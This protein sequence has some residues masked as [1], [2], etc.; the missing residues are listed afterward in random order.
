VAPV[1]KVSIYDLDVFY[2]LTNRFSLDLTIPY[3]TGSGGFTQGTKPNQRFVEWHANGIG[4]MTLQAEFWL[5]DTTKPSRLKGSVDLGIKAPTGSDSV[6]G[7]YLTPTGGEVQMPID[8]AAQP[9]NG[10]WELIFRAQ[11]QLELGGP[12]VAYAS[13]Y[14]GLSLTEHTSVHQTNPGGTVGPL[15][16]VPDTYS[17]RLGAG[18]LL[19][20]ADGLF[21]SVGGRINGVTVK[22]VIGGGD[23]YWRRPGYEVYVEPGLS[24]T[25]GANIASVSVP[26]RVYQNKLDSPLDQSLH[27]HVG[28]DFAPYLVV[29]SYARRF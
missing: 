1:R 20:F 25:L 7:L 27:R 19:P 2:G 13:G 15:R 17:G 21:L 12:F 9:G 26:L 8:E 24:W 29:A 28:S 22:D 3:V 16:S 6:E 11:G 23:L 10:G 14:Y 4:D 18:Y 5:N